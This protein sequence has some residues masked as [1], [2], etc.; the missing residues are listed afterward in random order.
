MVPFNGKVAVAVFFLLS[1]FVLSAGYFATNDRRRI[2]R[3]AIARYTRLA[4]PIAAA[5]TI[6]LIAQ[7]LGLILPM[8]LRPAIFHGMQLDT[9]DLLHFVLFVIYD[10]FFQY[11]PVQ[12][13]IGPLWTLSIELQGSAIVLAAVFVVGGLGYRAILLL[14][15]AMAMSYFGTNLPLFLLGAVFADLWFRHCPGSSPTELLAA[16]VVAMALPMFSAPS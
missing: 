11:D 12:T 7:Y 6:V 3:V 5:C 16:A 2:G 1:G 14:V 10:V 9:P 8:Q 15:G 13:Y 4:I